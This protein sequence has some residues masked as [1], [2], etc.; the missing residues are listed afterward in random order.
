MNE[1]RG[2]RLLWGALIFCALSALAALIL[3]R[4]YT[5]RLSLVDQRQR[6]LRTLEPDRRRLERYEAI[7]RALRDAQNSHFVL[8]TPPEGLPP[9]ERREVKRLPAV[10]DWRGVHI[11]MTW[12][13][14]A[15]ADALALVSHYAT[16]L[17]YWRLADVQIDASESSGRSRLTLLAVSV[18]PVYE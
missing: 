1:Q 17:P 9:P 13:Q 4:Q 5:T 16:N 12:P 10:G 14:V 3:H 7:E 11:E 15:N 6:L 8:P 2:Q 18:E